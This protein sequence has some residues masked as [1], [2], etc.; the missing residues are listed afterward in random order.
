[1]KDKLLI[2]GAGGH[3]KVAADVAKSMHNWSDICFLDDNESIKSVISLPVIGKFNDADKFIDEY[4]FFVAIGNNL[5][6]MKLLADLKTKGAS[7][8][9]L[10]HFNSI[11]GSD[12]EIGAGSVIMPGVIINS[13]SRIGK[14]CIINT[15]ASVDHDNIIE[16]Y[17]HLSPGVRLAGTVHVCQGSWIGIGGVVNN[18][19]KISGGNVSHPVIIEAGSV[20]V[21]DIVESGVYGDVPSNR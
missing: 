15:G 12:V 13:C 9:T 4:D 20:V 1:M 16:D 21:K 19:V 11:L 18:N 5:T 7:I 10:V 3:G 17:V 6:R 14:G 8:A 2:L